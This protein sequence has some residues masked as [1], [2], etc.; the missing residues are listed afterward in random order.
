MLI[1]QSRHIRS[2]GE[3]RTSMVSISPYNTLWINCAFTAET[4]S[5]SSKYK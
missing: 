1:D 5:M 4:G 2:M 3:F